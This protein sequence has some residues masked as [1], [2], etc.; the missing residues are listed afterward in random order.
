M[1]NDLGDLELERKNY[2]AA[3]TY[4]SEA[5]ELAEKAEGTVAQG[6][7]LTHLGALALDRERWAEARK[8]YEKALPLALE[9]GRQDLIASVKYGLSRVHEADGRPDLALPLAQEALAI[10]ERLRDANL[11]AARALVERLNGKVDI[12]GGSDE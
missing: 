4:Y 7:C 1:L 2:D 6:L 9:V 12:K 11:A 10:N 8:W 5:L 3:E